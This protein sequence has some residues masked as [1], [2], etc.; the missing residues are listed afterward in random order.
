MDKGEQQ[1]KR[2]IALIIV[3]ASAL[4]GAC[5]PPVQGGVGTPLGP[6]SGADHCTEDMPCFNCRTMGN[7]VCGTD[8]SVTVGVYDSPA[9][10]TYYKVTTSPREAARLIAQGAKFLSAID[11]EGRHWTW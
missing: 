2:Y 5:T 6:I 8:Q 4:L 1:V 7:H 10:T 9:R 3:C 11:K